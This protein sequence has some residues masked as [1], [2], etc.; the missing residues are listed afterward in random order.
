MAGGR[1]GADQDHRHRPGRPVEWLDQRHSLWRY[2]LRGAIYHTSDGGHTWTTQISGERIAGQLEF[3]DVETGWLVPNVFFALPGGPPERTLIYHTSDAG[4][5]PIGREEPTPDIKF[6]IVGGQTRD[7][8]GASVQRA[9][10]LLATVAAMLGTG[11]IL[12]RAR[13]RR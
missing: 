11:T 3:V 7:S 12:A 6:P 10:L 2:G 4:G 13:R 9:V 8:G 5:G 1:S